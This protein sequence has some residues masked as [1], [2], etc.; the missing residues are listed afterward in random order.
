MTARTTDHQFR[1]ALHDTD[2]AGVLFFGHL[3][4]H[5][6]DAYEAAMAR[7]GWPIDALIRKRQLALPIV[8]AAADYRQPIRHG[9]TI[10]VVLKVTEIAERRFN[11]AYGFLSGGQDVATAQSVHV[12]TDSAGGRILQLPDGLVAALSTL[13]QQWGWDETSS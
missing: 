9:D 2:A 1:V 7:I 13:P 8:H 4:R 11:L 3:F 5:A 12:A 10:D 6:H